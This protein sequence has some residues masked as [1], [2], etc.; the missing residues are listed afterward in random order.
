MQMWS[1]PVKPPLLLLV[2][3]IIKLLCLFF[4]YLLSACTTTHILSLKT[5][6]YLN[7]VLKRGGRGGA[8]LK[9]TNHHLMRVVRGLR[10]NL[11]IKNVVIEH[12]CSTLA[13]LER[14][15]EMGTGMSERGS[16]VWKWSQL[17]PRQT[18][19]GASRWRHPAF[20]SLFFSF[21]SHLLF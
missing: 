5:R 20:L 14:E 6:L 15:R 4:F 9:P 10:V 7:F 1:H 8:R 2:I 19:S 13:Y 16:C 3:T 21:S 18:S 17:V 12:A 11:V